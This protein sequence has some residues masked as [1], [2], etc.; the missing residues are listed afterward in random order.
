MIADIT[1]A[2]V[3]HIAKKLW[4]LNED[5][6]EK[7]GRPVRYSDLKRLMK[8]QISILTTIKTLVGLPQQQQPIKVAAN[9]TGNGAG[10]K[11]TPH[12]AVVRNSPPRH[13][14]PTG[15]ASC[16]ACNATERCPQLLAMTPDDRVSRMRVKG[17]RCLQSGHVGENAH[18]R[19]RN[20]VP[21]VVTI[22]RCSTAQLHH[23]QDR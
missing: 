19:S 10:H 12:G 20:A 15:C 3:K 1:E 21:V 16:G 14:D 22:I 6:K 23:H 2:R 4:V 8:R 9:L 7:E 11:K 17:I 13:Q 5:L 18:T